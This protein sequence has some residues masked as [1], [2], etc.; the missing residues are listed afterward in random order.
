VIE[1]AEKTYVPH[2]EELRHLAYGEKLLLL[3]LL[4]LLLSGLLG[5]S[6]CEG[7]DCWMSK[8]QRKQSCGM[9]CIRGLGV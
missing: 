1:R 7:L 2:L 3:L 5:E 6:V 8:D 9:N 4:L